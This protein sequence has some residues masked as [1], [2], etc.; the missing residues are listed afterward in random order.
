M[1]MERYLI[2]MGFEFGRQTVSMAE[3][4]F[5]VCYAGF[6]TWTRFVQLAAGRKGQISCYNRDFYS[7]YFPPSCSC[8]VCRVVE[9]EVEVEF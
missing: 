4:A 8:R 9:V 3:V 7:D 1:G 5:A 2:V 6:R